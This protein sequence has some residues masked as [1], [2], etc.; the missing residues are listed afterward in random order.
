MGALREEVRTSLWIPLI[1]LMFNYGANKLPVIIC[2]IGGVGGGR[3]RG[4]SHGFQD[5]RG[6]ISPN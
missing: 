1:W 3:I 5:N 6:G 2:R 4:G